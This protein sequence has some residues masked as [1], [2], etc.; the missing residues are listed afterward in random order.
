M[1]KGFAPLL[2]IVLIAFLGVGGYFVYTNYLNNPYKPPVQNTVD[3]TTSWKVYT[4]TKAGFEVKYPERYTEPYTLKGTQGGGRKV[5]SK[6]DD[7][8]ITWGDT[9]TG[10]FTI[11]FYPFDG[12][13]EEL[14]QKGRKGSGLAGTETESVVKELTVGGQKA[15]WTKVTSDV[16]ADELHRIYFTGNQHGFIF[17]STK[18]RSDDI[19]MR[20]L[21]DAEISQILSTFKFS[22]SNSS[23]GDW[24]TYVNAKYKYTLKYP[25]S[26]TIDELNNTTLV[27]FGEN[28]LSGTFY[29]SILDNLGVN[30]KDLTLLINWCDKFTNQSDIPMGSCNINKDR[31]KGGT[32]SGKTAFIQESVGEQDHFEDVYYVPYDNYVYKIGVMTSAPK[33]LTNTKTDYIFETPKNI[34]STFKFTK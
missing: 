22:E 20:I 19:P 8:G 32:L 15:I 34:L 25:V 6:E 26:A 16:S 13:V 9:S 31:H 18:V 11:E 30:I 10:V 33:E 23:I 5:T 3:E 28:N 14:Q 4:N 12:S 17:E 24:K 21:T 1:Q 2:I 27:L 7:L 29:V